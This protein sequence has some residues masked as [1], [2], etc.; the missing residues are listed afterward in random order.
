MATVGY[1][2]ATG[3]KE[4]DGLLSGYRWN[5]TL[6]YSFPDSASDYSAGYAYSEPLY[7][8]AQVSAAQQTVVHRAMALVTQYTNLTVQYS[9]TDGA[10]IRIA[11]SSEANP[12]A[13]AY[14]PDSNEGGDIWFGNSYNYRSP[15]LGNYS[16]LTHIHE[17]GHALGLKH[18]HEIEGPGNTALPSAHDSLEYTVMSY[19]AYTGQSVNTGY[20]NET[21]GF[22][23]TF[24]MNDIRALQQMYGADFTTQSSDTVYSWSNTTGEWFI[25]GVGQGRPGGVNAPASANVILMTVWDGDGNDTYDF[26]NY[27]TGVTVDLRPGAYSVTSAAQT[28]Y[29]GD[30]HS[31]KGSVYNAYLYGGDARSYIENAIGGTSNDTLVGNAVSNQL[32][33]GAGNDT[34]TGGTG[35][36][37][38]IFRSAYGADIVTDFSV[39]FD[40]VDLGDLSGFDDFGSVLA[41][42]SQ[43]GADALLSFGIG[44]SLKL[45]NVTFGM[46]TA[47]DFLFDGIA[48]DD[49]IPNEAPTDI[50][51]DNASVNEN[52]AGLIVGGITVA[53]MDDTG[54]DFD[55]SDNRFEV[56][57]T[58]GNY[59]LKLVSGIS[60][61][62]ET[63]PSVDVTV[64]ATDNGGLSVSESFSIAVNDIGG[65]TITGTTGRDTINATR[66][67][68]GQLNATNEDD[69]INAG[70]GADSVWGLAGNDVIDGGTGDDYLSGDDG[71]DRLIGGLGADRLY[72]GA[73]D[74]VFV[75]GGTEAASDTIVGGGGTDM[76]EVTGAGAITLSRFSSSALSIEAWVGNGEG[77]L[78][79]ARNDILD[80]SNIQSPSGLS[81]VD[82]GAGNDLITGTVLNDVLRG[83]AGNDMIIGGDGSDHITGGAGIDTFDGGAGDDTFVFGGTDGTKDVMRGG[84]GLDT[85]EI[86]GTADVTLARF[87]AGLWSIDAW[88]GNGAGVLGT[89]SADLLDFSGLTDVSGLS[90]LDGGDGNDKIVG[91]YGADII[92]GGTGN[93]TLAGSY[94][95]DVL[96]GGRGNDRFIVAAGGG[97]DII[98]DFEAGA[99]AGDVL[100]MDRSVF[101]NLESLLASS[102]QVG[103]DVVIAAPLGDTLTLQNVMLTNLYANDFSFV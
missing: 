69:I 44:L 20:A 51:L 92:R 68:R 84:S 73:G 25:D 48:A 39:G 60:L 46:L 32:D 40:Q 16:Y 58:T 87:D 94:G 35:S 36:D 6:T 79:T 10:D 27:T 28:A 67:V 54:F 18:S 23:T 65:A 19:R 8:F 33:G 12:T 83:G 42:A 99:R 56:T 11:Q 34:L 86:T 13:Y 88:H 31:A 61:D 50:T 80:F 81:Y 102:S 17:L 76:I 2:G 30:G 14:Y 101:A 74:D 47:D 43:V 37:V 26:S 29:L 85:V 97:N 100:I 49:G 21:Y 4:I 66:T 75:M 95:D 90:F 96:S 78:G 7:G 45:L 9:G 93:D 64:I 22:P 15:T 59:V 5:G 62:F 57:G 77:V 52:G 71:N 70:A 41:V 53:D 24:M 82:G 1:V 3:D 72:G 63:E 89:R 55:V 38:F 103:A 98:T 91:T